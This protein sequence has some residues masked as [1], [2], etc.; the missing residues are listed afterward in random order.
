MAKLEGKTNRRES[1]NE[2]M[3]ENCTI[4]KN[5]KPGKVSWSDLKKIVDC[6]KDAKTDAASKKCVERR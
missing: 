2:R 5:V 6:L 3:I 1:K 4:R